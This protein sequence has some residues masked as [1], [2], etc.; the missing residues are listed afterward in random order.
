[1]LNGDIPEIDSL[2]KDKYY[3]Y[4]SDGGANRLFE[5]GIKPDYIIG[6]M[7]SV[8]RSYLQE[9]EFPDDRF[10]ALE[11]QDTNDFEKSIRFIMNQG[12]KAIAVLGFSG[13]DVE[14]TF[15]NWSVMLKF[16]PQIPLFIINSNRM[17]FTIRESFVMDS[18]NQDKI[19]LI[20]FGEVYL[21]TKG[22][23]WELDREYLILGKREGASNMCLGDKVAVE[24]HD[25]VLTVFVP[26]IF[27]HYYVRKNRN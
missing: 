10:I 3:I 6:D 8:E 25:G 15:N 19:S 26:N 27:P 9:F 5:K 18:S 11:D 20:P 13:G 1:M 12:A 7:D 14:H 23:K 4:A 16:G 22:L 21:S 17:G 24:I 2:Q